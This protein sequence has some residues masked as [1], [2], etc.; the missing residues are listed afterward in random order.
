MVAVYRTDKPLLVQ[1]I[2]QQAQS[3]EGGETEYRQHSRLVLP[4]V[5]H[6]HVP[7]GRL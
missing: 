4:F 5:G 7:C 1:V 6:G 3:M 2:Q